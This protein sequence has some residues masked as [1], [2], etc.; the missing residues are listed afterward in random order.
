M[1]TP[2][3]PISDKALF[4]TNFASIKFYF[5][6]IPFS[7]NSIFNKFHFQQIPFSTN[8]IFNKFHFQQSLF[9]LIG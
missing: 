2:Q 6:Q 9:F 1:P 4:L 5:Q 8:S 3:N 7:T